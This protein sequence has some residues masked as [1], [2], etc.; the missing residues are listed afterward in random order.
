MNFPSSLCGFKINDCIFLKFSRH[1][2]LTVILLDVIVITEG[3]VLNQEKKNYIVF[4]A[5]QNWCHCAGLWHFHSYP[6]RT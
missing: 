2:L 1:S 6:A 3:S 5:V 4:S